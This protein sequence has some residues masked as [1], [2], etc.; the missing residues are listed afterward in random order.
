LDLGVAV[1]ALFAI[2]LPPRQPNVEGAYARRAKEEEPS[3]RAEIARLEGM[4]LSNPK[5]HR[6]A[7]ELARE[8]EQVGQH[9]QALRVAG[10]AAALGGPGEWRSLRAVSYAHAE[11]LEITP[12]LEYAERALESCSRQPEECDPQDLIRLEMV[13]NE[14]KSAQEAVAAGADPVKAPDEFRKKIRELHPA[15]RLRSRPGKR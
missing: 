3:V 2:V 12:A 7:E 1:I 11:R 14:L 6:A 15:V 13:R 5:D 4:L 10:A 9:D 8:L